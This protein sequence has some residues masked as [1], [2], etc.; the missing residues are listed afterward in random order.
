MYS[1]GPQLSGDIIL[2]QPQNDEINQSVAELNGGLDQHNMPLN[3][4]NRSKLAEPLQTIVG[5][6]P[7]QTSIVY[8]SQAYFFTEESAQTTVIE[9]DEW[10]VG[11]NKF[12]VLSGNDQNG[13][14]LNF[15][16]L[17]GM[18]KGEAC[19]D[20]DIRQSYE[21]RYDGINQATRLFQEHTGEL[22]VFVN[23]V[24]VA[25]TGPLWFACGRHSYVIPFG[26]AIGSGPC[27]ID[28]RWKINYKNT[29]FIF[30]AGFVFDPLSHI[31]PL[32][33]RDRMLW[34]RNEYR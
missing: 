25:R 34:V 21:L 9:N 27:H 22:G 29:Q 20:L 7:S 15:T 17:E 12:E 23:D 24:L 6:A 26:C 3:S 14:F 1:K 10:N 11:W 2:T 4:V 31:A 32:T 28:V 13:F 30:S 16:S 8:P 5:G 33:V 19:I 18:L